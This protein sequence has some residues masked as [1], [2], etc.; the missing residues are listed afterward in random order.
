MI[1]E[2][3]RN[4]MGNKLEAL[5]EEKREEIA[6]DLSSK[7]TE[8]SLWQEADVIGITL[9]GGLEWDT[10][11]T[12]QKAWDEGKTVVV[13]KCIHKTKQMDFYKIESYDEVKEGYVGILEPIP[14]KAQLWEKDKIELLV[15]PGRVFEKEGYR[16]GFGGGYYDRFLKDFENP[17][18]SIL[19]E[20]QFVEDLPIE[21]FDIPVQN[22]V[23]STL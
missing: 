5:A 15:V 19:W 9:S 17:T 2:Q 6:K 13:P 10:H 3:L 4:E 23:V 8:S 20:E 22:L 18:V 21:S 16:I 11:Q 1:K 14:E 7:L 12:I